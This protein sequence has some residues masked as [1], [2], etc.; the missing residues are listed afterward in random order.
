MSEFSL[1]LLEAKHESLGEP[2]QYKDL[3]PSGKYLLIGILTIM[4]V[5]SLACFLGAPDFNP[6]LVVDDDSDDNQAQ[7]PTEKPAPT[8]ILTPVA[9]IDI[10]EMSIYR[11]VNT[12]LIEGGNLNFLDDEPVSYEAMRSDFEHATVWW[13]EA[14]GDRLVPHSGVGGDSNLTM[15]AGFEVQDGDEVVGRI[16]VVS[17]GIEVS[18]M[19]YVSEL[20]PGVWVN[21]I[22]PDLLAGD[23]GVM[24][25]DLG[26][27]GESETWGYYG[28]NGS[29]VEVLKSEIVDGKPTGKMLHCRNLSPTQ[30]ECV[31]MQ[32]EIPYLDDGDGVSKIAALK[33]IEPKLMDK[34]E[35]IETA[36]TDMGLDLTNLEHI[37]H[38][39]TG[40]IGTDIGNGIFLLDAD[41]VLVQ[42]VDGDGTDWIEVDRDKVVVEDGKVVGL[43]GY[44]LDEEKGWV[45][46][47]SEVM[48]QSTAL[49]DQYGIDP[50]TYI[51]TE[52]D[53]V[54]VGTDSE[55][56]A[57][58]LR[59]GRL[60]IGFAVEIAAKSCE[61]TNFSPLANNPAVTKE[62]GNGLA[63]Y[64]F[65]TV[66]RS[67]GELQYTDPYF[68]IL[69]DR[70]LQCWGASEGQ[71]F[72]YRDK[73][74][75]SHE[76]PLIGLTKNEI[77][78]YV[79]SRE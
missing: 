63:Y 67:G 79:F 49:L 41:T 21:L 61:P 52:T 32:V 19:G 75:V 23:D 71:H 44:E 25:S 7:A 6:S 8:P 58:I 76:I 69:I 28:P 30:S 60:E 78:Q 16:G 45:E 57:E 34:L 11:P 53:G 31:V 13:Y 51:L 1:T 38:A 33:L 64:T 48:Q 50:E 74:G 42:V 72:Y 73:N 36:A 40:E 22:N 65:D 55:T 24:P 59:D 9:N 47:V 20:A 12:K 27:V 43:D 77:I 14:N 56:G 2:W 18:E 62:D 15:L 68:N 46:A 66:T 3:S 29:F 5:S 17:K 10:E 4:G 54:V 70:D 37:P 39:E 26:I 35:G